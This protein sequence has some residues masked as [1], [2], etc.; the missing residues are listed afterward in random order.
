M[1]PKEQSRDK[2]VTCAALCRT[3]AL[4]T[5]AELLAAAG[6]VQAD[7]LAFDFA[8]VTRDVTGGGQLRLERGVPV[9]QGAGDA[10]ANGAGLAGFTAA[11]DVDLDVEGLDVAGQHQRLLGD[12]D[13]GLAAEELFDVLAVDRDL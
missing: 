13:R 7:L 8:G 5:L 6:G 12:H 9:D 11:V 2:R 10:V 1:L 4:L 3:V